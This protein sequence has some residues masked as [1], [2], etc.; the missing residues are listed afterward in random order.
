M[1]HVTIME[2]SGYSTLK[3]RVNSWLSKN[4]KD[5]LEV[6]KIEYEQHGE[7]YLAMITY[8]ENK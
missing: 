7:I 8:E 6:I 3:G 5:I 4:K 1:K 2:Y